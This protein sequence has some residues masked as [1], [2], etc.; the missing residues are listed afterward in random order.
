MVRIRWGPEC[1]ERATRAMSDERRRDYVGIVTQLAETKTKLGIISDEVG[2]LRVKSHSMANDVTVLLGHSE[3]AVRVHAAMMA[4]IERLAANME[5][6]DGRDDQ[7]FAGV[8]SQIST[9]EKS[10]GIRD[11][12]DVA[13]QT[14]QSRRLAV[15]IA[16]IGLGSGV[17][18]AVAGA[19][20]AG[21]R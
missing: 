20:I 4:Q 8:G 14:H 5:Q 15:Y 6:H 17:V 3:E 10:L 16:I 9:I 7:R 1:Q 2:M 18:S 11:A 19:L 13:A 21:L 12:Q